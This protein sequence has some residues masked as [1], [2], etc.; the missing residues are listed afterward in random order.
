MV[1]IGGEYMSPDR[2]LLHFIRKNDQKYFIFDKRG[3]WWFC[4]LF[5]CNLENSADNSSQHCWFLF[6]LIS[7]SILVVISYFELE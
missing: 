7:H 6:Y 4:C 1:M 5:R 2:L 3:L